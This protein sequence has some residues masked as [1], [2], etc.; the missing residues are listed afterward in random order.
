MFQLS[1][2]SH[3]FL[4]VELQLQV[5]NFFFATQP[6]DNRAKVRVRGCTIYTFMC[7]VDAFSAGLFGSFSNT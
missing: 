7:C 3:V 2:E 4:L 1:F 5:D 6:G